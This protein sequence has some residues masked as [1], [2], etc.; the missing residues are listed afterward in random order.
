MS[1]NYQDEAGNHFDPRIHG[2]RI[3]HTMS[4]VSL[5]MYDRFGL[6]LRIE[7][8]NDVFFFPHYRYGAAVA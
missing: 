2:T 7:T 3:K 4:P 1:G 5:K 6:I 8:V